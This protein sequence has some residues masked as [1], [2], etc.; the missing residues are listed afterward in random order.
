VGLVVRISKIRM[1]DHS[2]VAVICLVSTL[3]WMPACGQVETTQTQADPIFR[4]SPTRPLEDLRSEALEATP[5]E[6]QGDFL[7]PDLVELSTLDPALQLDIRY[8]TNNN[9]LGVPFY[10][11]PRAYL[12]RPAAQALL[13]AH[14]E[15]RGKGLGLLIFDAYRPWFVTK[16]FWDATPGQYKQ[17]VANPA[18]GSRHNRG[19]AVDLTLYDLKTGQPL[20]MPS[21]YDEFRE[22]AHSDYPGGTRPQRENRDLLREVMEK[23]GFSVYPYE[24]WHFDF[25]GWEQYPIQNLTFD[26]LDE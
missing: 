4:I 10:R 1:P 6:E 9:F 21:G 16:M 19:A 18:D 23:H 25:R 5:P 24:W 7:E 14:L 22:K 3:V 2:I 13:N 20:V 26:E 11:Y 17:Y 12:Q 8:A 15:L